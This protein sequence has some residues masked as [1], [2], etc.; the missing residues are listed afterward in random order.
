MNMGSFDNEWFNIIESFFAMI[1]ENSLEWE[2][3]IQCCLY[4]MINICKN[5]IQNDKQDDNRLITQLNERGFT[6][7][8]R[9]DKRNVNINARPER[10]TWVF[11]SLDMCDYLKVPYIPSSY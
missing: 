1:S 3:R 6:K 9:L 7:Y 8:F 11:E 4:W 5:L 2:A 10:F